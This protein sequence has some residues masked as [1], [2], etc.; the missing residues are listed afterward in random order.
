MD[1]N[2]TAA[3]VLVA[4]HGSFS[5]AAQTLGVPKGTVSR[6]VARLEEHLGARLLQRTTRQ[7]GMT[8]V[9]RAYYERCRH[10]V[11][12]IEDAERLVS[13]VKGT[14]NGTLRVSLSTD[15]MR[16]LLL[17][18]L[19]ALRE[20]HPLLRLEIDV[21]QRKVD[22]VAEN[23]DVALRGGPSI[24]DSNLVVR[25]LADSGLFLYATPEYLRDRGTPRSIAD[26][27]KHECISFLRPGW[28][29]H[30]KLIGPEGPIDVDL[31]GFVAVNEIGTIHELTRA[32]YGIGICEVN[33]VRED[34]V[35]GRLR[36]VLPDFG[37]PSGGLWAVYPSKH[38]L[39]PKVR[40]FVD[41]VDESV[42]PWRVAP[43]A[44][45]LPGRATA[46]KK[47]KKG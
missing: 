41:F 9:G 8:E 42:A 47:A 37:I 39:S 11:E 36:P 17:P 12:E 2:D 7:V 32:G 13:D 28:S 24:E 29:S 38:H 21:S 20:R 1:L 23:I 45:A 15:L 43:R 35:Q 4:A 19:P 10:A 40:A 44:R 18:R 3:F 16:S 34:V 27:A 30:W 26:L 46:K 6:R 22:L 31:G 33:T 5:R 14:V 25:K